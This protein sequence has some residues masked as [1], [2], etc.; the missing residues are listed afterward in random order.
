[1]LPTNKQK[2]LK[3]LDLATYMEMKSEQILIYFLHA[4]KMKNA[5][6]F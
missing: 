6:Y 5:I 2:N 4:L 3:D 1:M